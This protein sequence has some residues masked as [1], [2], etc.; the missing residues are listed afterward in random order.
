MA[1]VNNETVTSTDKKTKKVSNATQD[2]L[3][4]LMKSNK[5]ISLEQALKQLEND[6]RLA[7]ASNRTSS[8]NTEVMN[9]FKKEFDALVD[10]FVNDKKFKKDGKR[11]TV[12]NI[13]NAIRIPK[14]YFA[15]SKDSKK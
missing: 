3:M 5:K 12:L 10:K 11:V 9:T 14:M 2:T 1:I 13:D 7:S 6:G 4:N 15:T 8:K